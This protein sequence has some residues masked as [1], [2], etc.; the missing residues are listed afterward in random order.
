V[1]DIINLRRLI[2]GLSETFPNNMPSW[3][4]V[5]TNYDFPQPAN[6]WAEAFP[7]VAN[8]NDLAANVLDA[9]F[10]GVKLGDVNNTASAN[11]RSN[12]S[13]EA[14][15]SA[16]ELE[17]PEVEMLVGA[18]YTI[19]VTAQVL[20]EYYGF[21]GELLLNR[22]KVRVRQ[23]NPGLLQ[24]DHF[25]L[26][27]E[28]GAVALSWNTNT[29]QPDPASAEEWLFELVLIPEENVLL[30]EA[31]TL[32]T[33]MIPAEAYLNSGGAGIALVFDESLPAET[34][35]LYQNQPNPFVATT[36][37]A[38]RLPASAPVD[39][40]ITDLTGRLVADFKVAGIAGRNS[41]EIDSKDL[42]APGVYTYTVTSGLWRESRR[43]VVQ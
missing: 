8:Y 18:E 1:G 31:L 4:F 34:Y 37:I 27:V 36:S 19:P 12:P 22:E 23:V 9:D 32:T 33:R 15:G 7:T 2:L 43:M 14:S 6:P 17:F 40:T 29:G 10:I 13:T 24:S 11:S 30:S 16:L 3:T 21:Q 38:F 42:G 25:A 26:D 5:R 28:R 35:H 39:I 20:G 41:I